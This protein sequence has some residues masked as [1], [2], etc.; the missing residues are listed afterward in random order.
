MYFVCYDMLIKK[1]KKKFIQ[2]G[3]FYNLNENGTTDASTSPS[4]GANTVADELA[5]L[6]RQNVF[7]QGQLEDKDRTIHLLQVI[8]S[9]SK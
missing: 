2:N 3:L 8:N 9:T 1:K 6:R 4:G 5:D 7:L